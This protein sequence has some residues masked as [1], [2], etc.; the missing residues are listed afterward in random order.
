[1]SFFSKLTLLCLF[2]GVAPG[3]AA[4]V[5]QPLTSKSVQ[6]LGDRN[7]L[8]FQPDQ[9]IKRDVEESDYT[10]IVFK[11]DEGMA[12]RDVEESDYTYI[13]FK[14]DEGMAKRDVEESDYTYIVFKRDEG[15]AKRDVEESDYT[16]IVF[17]R[18]EGNMK[19]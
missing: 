8:P 10:Y 5:H 4:V 9:V 15:M 17:K 7:A 18:D 16:Y 11:R 1:M 3:L 19:R 14:R 2:A 12:K 13:V 6:D